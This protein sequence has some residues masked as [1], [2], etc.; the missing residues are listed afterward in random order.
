MKTDSNGIKYYESTDSVQA[1][2]AKTWQDNFETV[3]G[4]IDELR[5][6]IDKL[7]KKMQEKVNDNE[8]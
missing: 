7:E 4:L 1:Y 5:Q 3:S 6:R 2:G 8:A